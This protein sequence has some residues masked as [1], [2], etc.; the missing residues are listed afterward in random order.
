MIGLVL[1]THGPLAEA[2]VSSG[3]LIVGNIGNVAHLGLFHG[4]SI[5]QFEQKVYQAIEQ[6]DEGDGVIVLTDLLGGSPCNVTAKAIGRLYKE[7]S[8]NAFT[9]LTFPYFWRL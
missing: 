2:F 4:D 3:K 9:V 7:K 5:E 6:A 8:W 1:A